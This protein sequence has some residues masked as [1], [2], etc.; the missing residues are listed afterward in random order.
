MVDSRY[1]I[2]NPI[3]PAVNE[4]KKSLTDL[5]QR[6]HLRDQARG[7]LVGKSLATARRNYRTWRETELRSRASSISEPE[8]AE[9]SSAEHLIEFQAPRQRRQIHSRQ[10]SPT[11]GLDHDMS[12]L[13][14]GQSDVSWV[15]RLPTPDSMTEGLGGSSTWASY[16][17]RMTISPS[18]P[19][20]QG[21]PYIS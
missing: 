15:T 19:G 6:S 17:P 4:Q 8:R 7:M 14:K 1:Y 11:K 21:P 20:K 18:F 3:S 10:P 5:L 16:F 12:Q 9:V 2:P 13:I